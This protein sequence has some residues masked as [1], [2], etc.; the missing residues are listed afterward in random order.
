MV[1]WVWSLGENPEAEFRVIVCIHSITGSF[2]ET[3][4]AMEAHSEAWGC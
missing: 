2:L 3:E 4:E 1:F